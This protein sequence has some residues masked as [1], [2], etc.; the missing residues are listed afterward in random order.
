MESVA[1]IKPRNIVPA[2]QTMQALFTSNLQKT[3]KVGIN[4]VRKERTKR[5]LFFAARELS[6]I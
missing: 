6:A 3:N 2:S 1:T 5:E 4:I